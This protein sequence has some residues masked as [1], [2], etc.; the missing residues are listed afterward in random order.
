[1]A[2][3][4]AVLLVA[5]GGDDDAADADGGVTVTDA[6][7]RATPGGVTVGAVY[8][9]VTSDVDDELLGATVDPGVA[10]TVDL[11]ATETAADGTATMEQ[12]DALAVPAGGE[13]VLEPIGNHLMLVGL[14]DALTVGESFEVTLEF[15]VAGDEV[16]QVEV[17]EDAP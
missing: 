8:L 17:R 9:S 15:A 1:M 7:A 5:C 14:A 12:Q 6:W 11:H 10:A 13:L 3:V 4:A 2:V 16:V